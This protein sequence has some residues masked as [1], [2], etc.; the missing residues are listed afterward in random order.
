MGDIEGYSVNFYVLTDILLN[1][2]VYL[3]FLF[4]EDGL[5]HIQFTKRAGVDICPNHI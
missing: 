4:G 1:H 2:F 5:S 3:C